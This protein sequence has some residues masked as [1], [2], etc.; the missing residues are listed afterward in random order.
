M[1]RRT[2]RRPGNPDTRQAILDAARAAF[3]E[4]GF[5]G[6]S[7]RAVAAAAQ[8]DPALVHHYFGSKDRLFLAAM[9]APVD[10]AEL[11]PRVLAGDRAGLGERLV[12]TFLGVWDSPAGTA[13]V[14][15][16]RSAVSNEW[17]ARLLREF[18]VT[19]VL[20]RILDQLDVDPAELPLRGSLVASQLI[21]LAVM[22]HVVRLEP[23]ASAAPETLVAAVGPTVQRYLTGDLAEVFAG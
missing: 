10:P 2:G 17:T 6:A 7:I 1:A 22:R 18:L 12:R 23:V 14:A 8:V 9:H 11:L 4:R 3:A 19:Q 16:L 13:G 20:R 15:L 5:D 21:G